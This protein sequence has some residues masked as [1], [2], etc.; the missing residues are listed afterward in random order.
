MM[1]Q[2]RPQE[3]N[4]DQGEEMTEETFLKDLYLFMKQRDTPIDRLPHL[5]FKQI[6]LFLMYKTVKELGGYQQVTA[7]QLWKKVYNILGGNP[8]STSAATCTRRHYEKLLLAYECHQT[9]YGDDIAFRTPQ[10]Q[11]RFHPT[12]YNDFEHKYPRIGKRVDFRHIPAFQTSPNMFTD[13]QRQIFTMPMNVTPYFTHG[14]TSLPNYI[15]LRESTLP[16]LG[17]NPKDLPQT[18]A[19]YLAA[20]TEQIQ[21]SKQ[22]LDR[23]RSLA[24][25]YKSSAGW[26]EPLNL[27][28]KENRLE[29][30]SDTPS[31]FSPPSSKKPKFLNEASPLYPP[32]GLTTEEGTEEDETVEGTYTREG[33]GTVQ[34]APS[35]VLADVIDLT[36]SSSS[37]PVPRRASPP[38][39]HLFNRRLNLPEPSAM[40]QREQDLHPD[41][42]KQEPSITS[43]PNLGLLNQSNPHG[44]PPLDPNGNM[45]IQIPLKFLQE[46]IR[47]GLLSSPALTGHWSVSQDSTKAEAQP[48]PKFHVRSC[49]ETSESSTKGEELANWNLKSPAK[50]LSDASQQDGGLKKYRSFRSNGLTEESKAHS[51]TSSFQINGPVKRPFDRDTTPNPTHLKQV[52]F[53]MTRNQERLSP[54][55]PTYSEDIPLSLTM[56][57]GIKSEKV[58]ATS[59][60]AAKQMSSSPPLLQVTS[61]HLK[62]LLANLHYRLERGQTF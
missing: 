11:K 37:N 4:S 50:N 2:N 43:K 18:P 41:W 1:E 38:S 15:P 33:P 52:Q 7:L 46:L 56:K 6:D 48:E 35:P 28:Q 32:R 12:S 51:M 49:S 44:H 16:Q 20:L 27:S 29:T 5:G 31:S 57:S 24:K 39:V 40:K 55:S 25:E 3:R 59:S 8:R 60:S 47:R 61:D 42:L 17:L 21:S 45:K 14:S 62:L 53:S 30:L 34:A 36:Y 26:E 9:G 54:K 19:S 22:P 23:L 13:H 58:M 10:M